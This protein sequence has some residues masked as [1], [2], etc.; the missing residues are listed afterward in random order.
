MSILRALSNELAAIADAVAPAVLHVGTLRSR[1]ARGEMSGGSGVVI[2]GDGLA[3]TNSHVVHG[4]VGV[5]TTLADGR[6]L[7]ADV[8]GD[9]PATDLALLRLAGRDL[10]HAELGDSNALRVGEFVTAVGSPFGLARTV[11]CGIVSALGR[12]LASRVAGRAIEGVIQTDAPLNPGNSGGP[13]LS[14][15]G[16]VVGINTAI[17]QFA[18]GLCFAVPSNTAAFV[19]GELASHGRV[20]RAWLGIGAE[21]VLLPRS[22]ATELGLAEPRGVAVRSVQPGSPAAKAGVAVGDILVEL[23]GAGLRTVADL[24]RALGANALGRELRLVVVRRAGSVA[25]SI[26]PDELR[27]EPR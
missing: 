8:V 7:L 5:E 26:A 14:A 23:D 2:S 11:T 10:A 20:R 18:Q 3:L 25:L 6:T 13:L 9:D 22:R 24:H 12:T 16:R 1:G 17:V 4:A 19:V 21:E 15:E 27:L